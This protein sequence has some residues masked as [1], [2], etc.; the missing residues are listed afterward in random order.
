[1]VFRS[2]KLSYIQPK[3]YVDI[4]NILNKQNNKHI[5]D[6][7]EKE[8]LY[9]FIDT[10]KTTEYGRF[11]N[12]FYDVIFP[13]RVMDPQKM[14]MSIVNIRKTEGPASL[15]LFEKSHLTNII[16]VISN[17]FEANRIINILTKVIIRSLDKTIKPI[18][19]VNFLLQEKEK[20]IRKIEDFKDVIEIRVEETKDPYIRN[21]WLQGSSL[22]ES[23]EY[24]KFVLDPMFAG[25]MKFIAFSYKDTIYYLINDGRIF[26][27]QAS[28][29]EQYCKDIYEIVERLY[30]IGAVSF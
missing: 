1:M 11:I 22:D 28:D 27:R 16:G 13:I 2:C 18:T 29:I 7:T 15:H 6:E 5:Y 12:V 20:E 30:E 8:K 25:E 9:L 10:I 19:M 17:V 21:L 26:T 4:F 3:Y 24:K 14:S 23:G